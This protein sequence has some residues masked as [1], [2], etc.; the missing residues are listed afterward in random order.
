M[1]R[2]TSCPSRSTGSSSPGPPGDNREVRLL[3]FRNIAGEEETVRPT[4]LHKFLRESDRTWVSAGDLTPGDVLRSH[5]GVVTVVA[6]YAIGGVHRVYNMTVEGEHVYQVSAF[7]VIAHNNDAANG[8]RI[9]TPRPH[10]TMHTAAFNQAVENR[11][12]AIVDR[13]TQRGY[14]K[15]AIRDAL[16]RELR[17]IGRIVIEGRAP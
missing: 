17:A 9:D 16:R 8:I 1:N 10:N 6:N 3:T 5:S 7:G 12:Q 15:N 14:G 13:M 11:L 4:R 2:R